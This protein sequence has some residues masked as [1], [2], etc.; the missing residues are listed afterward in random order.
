MERKRLSQARSDSLEEVDMVVTQTHV[1]E[2]R[3][4]SK[5]LAARVSPAYFSV[6][7]GD[8]ATRTEPVVLLASCGTSR[9]VES[10]FPSRFPGIT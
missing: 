10:K 1:A 7:R 8:E 5:K 9:G 3:A 6:R 2:E 4:R